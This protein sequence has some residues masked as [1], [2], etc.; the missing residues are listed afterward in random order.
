MT[1]SRA[2]EDFIQDR[3]AF[4][5]EV[6]DADDD[7]D[8]ERSSLA[9]AAY[10]AILPYRTVSRSPIDGE[11][12]TI[13]FDDVDLDGLWWDAYEPARGDLPDGVI[14]F[15]GAMRLSDDV[16]VAPFLA[17]PGPGVP[18]VHPGLLGRDGVVG[19]VSSV[20]VGR[21]IGYPIVYYA[22]SVPSGAPLL[23]W[24]GARSYSYR[25]AGRSQAGENPSHEGDWDYDLAP[26][27]RIQKLMWIAP[28]DEEWQLSREVEG[29]PYIDLPG[30]KR[31][32][33]VQ[34]GDVWY[35]STDV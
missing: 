18:F 7:G 16:A 27:I 29:C 1:T 28:G 23:D 8:P 14:S 9:R 32:A 11:L 22:T 5:R 4:L 31:I 12:T 19:V 2:D 26:W 15:G 21:H 10:V 13:K 24:W 30:E 35:S 34:A 6:F 3:A 20:S 17:S 33:R 25:T